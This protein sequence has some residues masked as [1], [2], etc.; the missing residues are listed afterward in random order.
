MDLDIK[1]V[2]KE[3]PQPPQQTVKVSLNLSR[4]NTLSIGDINIYRN[5]STMGTH[6]LSSLPLSF[7]AQTFV[8]GDKLHIGLP[9]V[10]VTRIRTAH[11]VNDDYRD[12]IDSGNTSRE[13]TIEEGSTIISWAIEGK[14]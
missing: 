14:G 1:A 13:I 5:G 4:N 2:S 7:P 9:G 10:V 11:R 8:V 6:K 12:Y 3:D